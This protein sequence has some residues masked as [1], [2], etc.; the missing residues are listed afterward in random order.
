MVKYTGIGEWPLTKTAHGSCNTATTEAMW[1]YADCKIA[2]TQPEK[3]L[4][5]P[6]QEKIKLYHNSNEKLDCAEQEKIKLH[7]KSKEKLDCPQQ[8]IKG[9]LTVLGQNTSKNSTSPK[10]ETA[11]QALNHTTTGTL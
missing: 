9:V 8:E 1:V 5:C 4:N 11:R 6:Q 2:P 10:Q 3:K 7:H